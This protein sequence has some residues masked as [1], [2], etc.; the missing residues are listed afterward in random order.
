MRPL[1][2]WLLP[3]AL[4]TLAAAVGLEV[5]AWR[6]RQG[7]RLELGAALAEA[8]E[9]AGG[10][11]EQELA[12]ALRAAR[13]AHVRGRD[14]GTALALVRLSEEH[15]TAL[16]FRLEALGLAADGGRER[17]AARAAERAAALQPDDPRVQALAERLIDEATWGEVRELTRPA[18]AVAGGLLALALLA[19]L[20]RR[21]R[22]RARR[23]WVAGLEVTLAGTS[24]GRAAPPGVPIPVAAP[25]ADVALDVFLRAPVGVS[26]PACVGP[27]LALVLSHARESHSVRLTPI[28]D[29]RQEAVRVRLSPE[30]LSRVRSRPGPWR[31]LALLDGQPVAEALLS[32]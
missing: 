8:S 17:W 18:A 29:L 9:A 21:G 4:V 13:R 25:V 20:H 22:R 14:A 15:P 28:R 7:A 10:D 23:R 32:A 30:T 19:A 31:A 1:L 26:R 12:E 5:Q 27:T 3:L 2:R 6:A 11:G 24:D 16:T